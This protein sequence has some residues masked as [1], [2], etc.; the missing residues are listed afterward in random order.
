MSS[1]VSGNN[2][3]VFASGEQDSFT[4]AIKAEEP[5]A[6]DDRIKAVLEAIRKSRDSWKNKGTIDDAKATEITKSTIKN[7]MYKK[8]AMYAG[9][10]V[11]VGGVG[12]LGY[13]WMKNRNP[14]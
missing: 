5:S 2:D 11:A 8:Y 10:V 6:S 12:Y 13:R 3:A 4:K 7:L 14:N 9:A 1:S